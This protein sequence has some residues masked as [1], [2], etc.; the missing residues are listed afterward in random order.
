MNGAEKQTL[1]T[2]ARY[3]GLT[4]QKVLRR[5]WRTLWLRKELVWES[6]EELGRRIHE[7]WRL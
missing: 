7:R 1:E 2:M 5:T 4:H 3:F 6:E